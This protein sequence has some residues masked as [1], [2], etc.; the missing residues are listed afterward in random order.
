MADFYVQCPADLVPESH[1]AL[2][3][4]DH[5]HEAPSRL[6][7]PGEF[8]ALFMAGG[9]SNT[10]DWQ[11]QI[12]PQLRR[13]C[14]KLVLVNPRRESFDVSNP[15]ETE[16]QINWEHRHLRACD[17]IMFW[18]PK[19]TLCPITLYELG[20][21]SNHVR[22]PSNPRGPQ[23]G[24]HTPL[25]VGVEPEYA[26]RED[27]IIQTQLSRPETPVVDSLDELVRQVGLWYDAEM[28]TREEQTAANRWTLLAPVL[29]GA[30]GMLLQSFR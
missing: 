15:N 6:Y 11:S 21:W 9:I 18:F 26:R 14:P 7:P 4:G 3:S 25:I 13:R 22:D 27:I 19:E 10:P 1:G 20:V 23:R 16:W 12:Q 5:A 29:V 28:E 30:V 17:A 24:S 8:P 2:G